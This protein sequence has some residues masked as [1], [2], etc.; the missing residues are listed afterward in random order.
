[1]N[2][3]RLL[4]KPQTKNINTIMIYLLKKMIEIIILGTGQKY[5]DYYS[6]FHQYFIANL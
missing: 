5:S 1:M 4:T 3:I 2:K 6:G